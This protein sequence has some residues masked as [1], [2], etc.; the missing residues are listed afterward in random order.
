MKARLVGGISSAVAAINEVSK[1]IMTPFEKDLDKA[2]TMHPLH[3]D[4]EVT[5]L[6]S[7][8]LRKNLKSALSMSGTD[9]LP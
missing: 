2:N 7:E 5:V 1:G 6:L 8:G 4:L 3:E 9:N